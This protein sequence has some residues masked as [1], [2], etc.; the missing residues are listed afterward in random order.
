MAALEFGWK[1]DDTEFTSVLKSVTRNRTE[2]SL[3]FPGSNISGVAQ[4][5]NQVVGTGHN[6][7]DAFNCCDTAD[8]RKALDTVDMGNDQAK[9]AAVDD[10]GQIVRPDAGYPDMHRKTGLD[11][12][13]GKGC[14]FAQGHG[15]VLHVSNEEIE[16]T[17]TR[18]GE[19]LD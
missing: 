11:T 5:L 12:C 6:D 17:L 4:R 10:P 15:A 9:S 2:R 14:R 8:G 18:H 19:H 16:T 1:A 13:N 7:I 3:H